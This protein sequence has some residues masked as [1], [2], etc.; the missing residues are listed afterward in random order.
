MPCMMDFRSVYSLVDSQSVDFDTTRN[1]SNGS[2]LNFVST[3]DSS[4][5]CATEETR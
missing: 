1:T 2:I 5:P 3:T 4:Y